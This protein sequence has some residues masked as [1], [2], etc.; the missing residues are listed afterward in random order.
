MDAP[1][2]QTRIVPPAP[3]LN[4]GAGRAAFQ[5]N[6]AYGVSANPASGQGSS[7]TAPQ[8]MALGRPPVV[9]RVE[10]S[11]SNASVVG[12]IAPAKAT[13]TTASLG[14]AAKRSEG[15]QSLIAARVEKQPESEFGVD[16]V[17]ARTSIATPPTAN[18]AFPMYNHPADRNTA[19]T[20]VNANT[21]MSL[22]VQA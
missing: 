3:A 12:K 2:V 19:A 16:T 17:S 8:P 4:P 18:G 21:G 6:R 22:D 11:T 10:L 7:S 15:I 5:L 14:S 20:R 9:D 1:Q 13:T